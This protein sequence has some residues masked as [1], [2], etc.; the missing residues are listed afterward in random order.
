MTT[1]TKLKHCRLPQPVGIV[2]V[3]ISSIC[4]NN[5]T[6]LFAYLSFT[7]FT[8]S[9][10]T[11]WLITIYLD[12]K[13]HPENELACFACWIAQ[14]AFLA[15]FVAISLQGRMRFLYTNHYTLFWPTALSYARNCIMPIS[16]NHLGRM[17]KIMVY[18]FYSWSERNEH[19]SQLLYV[20]VHHWKPVTSGRF[21]AEK[22]HCFRKE[23]PDESI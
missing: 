18:S 9:S 6:R 5:E 14:V 7:N 11:A 1:G 12:Y 10:T 2:H 8:C 13:R 23:N 19:C 17:I 21:W 20:S 3:F 16:L 4:T 15:P 22:T